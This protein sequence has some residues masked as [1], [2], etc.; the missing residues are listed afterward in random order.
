[1]LALRVM[2][3]VDGVVLVDVVVSKRD[4]GID[5]SLVRADLAAGSVQLRQ[6]I[7]GQ[8]GLRQNARFLLV[9]VNAHALEAGNVRDG[10]LIASSREGLLLVIDTRIDHGDLAASAGVACCPSS[11]GA[12]LRRRGSHVRIIGL[13][14]VDHHGFVAVFNEN[15]LDA[16]NLCD[17]FD[18][19]VADV[20]RNDV[21]GKG[22]VPNNVD[23]V[24]QSCVDF[25]DHAVLLALQVVTVSDGCGAQISRPKLFD[26]GG[27]FQHDGDTND[28]ALRVLRV[29][30]A[31]NAFFVQCGL[32]KLFGNR[33]VQL[34]KLQACSLAASCGERRN[35]KSDA[36]R[37]DEE[38]GKKTDREM[39]LHILSFF[40]KTFTM[41]GQ[42]WLVPAAEHLSPCRDITAQTDRLSFFTPIPTVLSVNI[43][44]RK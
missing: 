44:P 23:A 1:M 20:C 39:F 3:M 35:N 34:F 30:A 15:L 37:K 22:Q 28:F 4:L 29:P 38:H 10:V 36:H 16:L 11:A 32:Q 43:L 24:L 27:I 7:S 40:Q 6:N 21:A 2:H 17:L 19:L 8:V 18:L 5:I 25:L 13:V 41:R 31:V 33:I 26:S 12:D 14:L 42:A 9:L